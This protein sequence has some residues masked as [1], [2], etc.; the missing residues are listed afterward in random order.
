MTAPYV[1]YKTDI[2]PFCMMVRGFLSQRGLELPLKDTLL[3]ATARAELV[4]GGGRATVPCLR[5]ENADG[6]YQWMYESRD[7]MAF[8][9]EQ[10]F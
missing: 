3:D 5:I 9:A 10:E 7:I 2:C 8:L 6:S 4:A 1:L